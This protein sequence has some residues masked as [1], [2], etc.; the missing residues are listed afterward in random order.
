MINDRMWCFICVRVVSYIQ[1]VRRGI[2]LYNAV[3]IMEGITCCTRYNC[4]CC[5][6]ISMSAIS[7][8]S[9]VVTH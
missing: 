4:L 6:E 7:L 3:S 2:L 5:K 8:R 9:N 1:L